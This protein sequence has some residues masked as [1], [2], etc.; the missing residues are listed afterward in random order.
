[1][2]YNLALAIEAEF[3]ETDAYNYY[4]RVRTGLGDDLLLELEKSYNKI[5]SNPFHYSYLEN[6][7]I[8]RHTKV[9]RFP[10]IVIYLVSTNNIIVLSVRNTHRKPFV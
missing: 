4:E 5:V 10:Y 3:E 9:A 2:S 7:S 8:L 1:M 6:S